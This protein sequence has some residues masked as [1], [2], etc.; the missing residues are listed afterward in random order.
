MKITRRQ[1]KQIINEALSFPK[2]MSEA[3]EKFPYKSNK[4]SDYQAR[5]N[6]FYDEFG[7]AEEAGDL[8]IPDYVPYD[9]PGAELPD[10]RF[11]VNKQLSYPTDA[12]DGTPLNTY[13]IELY[14]NQ[15]GRT[16]FLLVP[17]AML[18]SESESS[19]MSAVTAAAGKAA[20]AAAGKEEKDLSENVVKPA[21]YPQTATGGMKEIPID[22]QVYVPKFA[23]RSIQSAIARNDQTPYD[24]G[25]EF[26]GMAPAPN[27]SGGA[28][29]GRWIG[30]QNY[31]D[32]ERPDGYYQD[33][34][35][36]MSD[37][38][39]RD[40]KTGKEYQVPY[41]QGKFPGRR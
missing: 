21:E 15:E 7:G 39:I 3:V 36:R 25:F 31:S 32:P 28:K 12:D 14:D 38:V 41:D 40:K 10:L 23:Q 19:I 11:K 30:I 8:Y 1:L 26:I 16:T 27:I 6:K 35:L 33:V 18:K 24:S 2:V 13:L 9:L 4:D 5:I 22:G 20:K 37:V 34:Y 17:Y 29:G